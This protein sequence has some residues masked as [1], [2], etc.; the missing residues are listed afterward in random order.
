MKL[1]AP[2]SI[3]WRAGF[4]IYALALAI[5]THWPRLRIESE[6][7]ERPDILIHVVAFGGWTLALNLA[8]WVSARAPRG[9]RVAACAVVA[10]LYACLDEGTQAIPALGRTAAWDDLAADFSGV[11]LGSVVAYGLLRSGLLKPASPAP[12]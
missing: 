6:L 9:R 3:L 10:A 4:V 8:A 11:L 7:M 5:A 2:G 1:P 12:G